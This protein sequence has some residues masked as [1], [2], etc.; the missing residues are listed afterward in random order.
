MSGCEPLDLA[1]PCWPLECSHCA[2]T[3]NHLTT[4]DLSSAALLLV[5]QR[6]DTPAMDA[7]IDILHRLLLLAKIQSWLEAG[8][9]TAKAETSRGR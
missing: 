6:P 2:A 1:L 9:A 8:V 4:H 5:E 3:V 7:A